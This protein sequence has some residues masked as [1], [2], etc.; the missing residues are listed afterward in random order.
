M[1]LLSFPPKDMGVAVSSGRPHTHRIIDAPGGGGGASARLGVAG[2]KARH[3]DTAE[4][5]GPDALFVG[6][7]SRGFFSP[8]RRAREKKKMRRRQTAK[9]RVSAVS[10][11]RRASS[12]EILFRLPSTSAPGASRRSSPP[13]VAT[14]R[15]T[16]RGFRG[17]DAPKRRSS[18]RRPLAS[19]PPPNPRPRP[20]SRGPLSPCPRA[21]GRVRARR[22][23]L[24]GRLRASGV[25]ALDVA[26]RRARGVAVPAPR[27]AAPSDSSEDVD[28]PSDLAA[29]SNPLFT[30]EFVRAFT[31]A[32]DRIQERAAP[33]RERISEEVAQILERVGTERD[34]EEL[35]PEE[36]PASPED[37][38]RVEAEEQKRLSEVEEEFVSTGALDN[39]L[40]NEQFKRTFLEAQARIKEKEAPMRAKIN[41]EVEEIMRRVNAEREAAARGETLGGGPSS[42]TTRTPP[43]PPI[44]PR[45][46]IRETPFARSIRTRSRLRTPDTTPPR[47]SPPP[48]LPRNKRDLPPPRTRTTFARCGGAARR[49]WRSSARR[50]RGVERALRAETTQLRRIDLAIEKAAREARYAEA[51]KVARERREQREREEREAAEERTRG[52]EEEE[53]EEAAAGD[54]A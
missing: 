40:F 17:G 2:A 13:L 12:Q 44:P 32:Q 10:A 38:A 4:P 24:P 20:H 19:P 35:L 14:P 1:S 47:P 26:R 25:R 7:D 30:P 27:A 11:F 21:R 3:D 52:E 53:E 36:E 54:D 18:T 37:I 48:P 6:S 39:P 50:S 8:R 45:I 41:A 5:R 9:R 31:E 29:S 42:A 43:P 15:R 23:L 16:P 22:V 34:L 49:R 51:E 28:D 46:R 33:D